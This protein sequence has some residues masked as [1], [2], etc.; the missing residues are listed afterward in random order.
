[1]SKP[2]ENAE[3]EQKP[4]ADQKPK[5]EQKPKKAQEP[6]FLEESEFVEVFL[7]KDEDD[8]DTHPVVHN[9]ELF[10]VPRGQRVAV[11]RKVFEIL[12]NARMA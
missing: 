1:M 5:A 6:K 12:Q 10:Y 3:A 4:E 2:V 7:H 11:P 8:P 9:G